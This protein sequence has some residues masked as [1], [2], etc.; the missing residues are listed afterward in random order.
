[1]GVVKEIIF[2]PFNY[3]EQN[4]Y[5]KIC[6]RCVFVIGERWGGGGVV[7]LQSLLTNKKDTIPFNFQSNEP[8]SKFLRQQRTISKFLSHALR[9]NL[10]L[11]GVGVI[12]TPVILNLKKGTRTSDY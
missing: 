10:R 9:E 11:G 6:I 7:A 5:A 8:F 12:H 3:T 1:M 2:R 4:G